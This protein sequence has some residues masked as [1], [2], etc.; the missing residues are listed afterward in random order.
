MWG[1]GFFLPPAV[2]GY[3][4][5]HDRLGISENQPHNRGGFLV[6]EQMV[7]VLRVF[8]I[9]KRGKTPGKLSFLRFQKIRGMDFLGNILAVH[10]VQDILER[11]DVV[12]IPQVSIPSFMAI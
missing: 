8:P 10:L 1:R 6:N 12:V 3:S 9:P 7:F 11:G 5:D 2:C 4:S